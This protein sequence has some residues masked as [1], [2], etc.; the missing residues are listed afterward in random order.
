[1]VVATRWASLLYS[2]RQWTTIALT[3]L[4]YGVRPNGWA[5]F[6]SYSIGH[7]NA[8][9]FPYTKMSF[10]VQNSDLIP[11]SLNSI[12]IKNN[13]FEFKLKPTHIVNNDGGKDNKLSK[14][15]KRKKHK[16]LKL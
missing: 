2:K 9:G 11:I 5:L 10:Q 8:P 12:L 3:S 1:M 7:G 15:K 16:K 6:L 13:E 14:R 4:A